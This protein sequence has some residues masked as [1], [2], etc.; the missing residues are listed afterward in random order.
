LQSAGQALPL[1]SWLILYLEHR[2]NQRNPR[3]LLQRMTAKMAEIFGGNASHRPIVVRPLIAAI[4]PFRF[5]S[6]PAYESPLFQAFAN[7]RTIERG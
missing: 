5:T 6:H 2:I 7:R 1:H 4:T 3:Y